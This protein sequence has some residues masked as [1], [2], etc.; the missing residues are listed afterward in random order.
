M[1]EPPRDSLYLLHFDINSQVNF[2][3]IAP[4]HKFGSEGFPICTKCLIALLEGAWKLRI[5]NDCFSV[6]VMCMTIKN[7]NT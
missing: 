5:A 7:L 4:N 3:C 2:I 6:I 1:Q